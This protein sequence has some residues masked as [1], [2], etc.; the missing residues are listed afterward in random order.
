MADAGR[1]QGGCKA[2]AGRMQGGCRVEGVVWGR[3][4]GVLWWEVDFRCDDTVHGLRCKCVMGD[5]APTV[6]GPGRHVRCGCTC[7]KGGMGRMRERSLGE[8][9]GW[10]GKRALGRAWPCAMGAWLRLC[11]CKHETLDCTVYIALGTQFK[12]PDGCGSVQCAL[13]SVH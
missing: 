11:A 7:G 9:R 6:A 8:G 5:A 10:G 13:T 2:D 12:T 4:R 3:E 1:M